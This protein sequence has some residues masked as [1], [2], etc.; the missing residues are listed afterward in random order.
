MSATVFR[1]CRH[2]HEIYLW[3]IQQSYCSISC[4]EERGFVRRA[5]FGKSTIEALLI[6][7]ERGTEG[8]LEENRILLRLSRKKRPLV[9]VEMERHQHLYLPRFRL[10]RFGRAVLRYWKKK[11][12][13]DGLAA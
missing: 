8:V 5:Q 3:N 13:I 4:A 1:K 11:G 12:L 7:E 6:L 10:T 9:S 2:C